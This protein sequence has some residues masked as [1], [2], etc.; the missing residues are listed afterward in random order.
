M[1]GYHRWAGGQSVTAS[2][3]SCGKPL[4][5]FILSSLVG[6]NNQISWF[7]HRGKRQKHSHAGEFQDFP[8]LHGNKTL[9]RQKIQR[10]VVHEDPVQG[11]Q[12]ISPL[13]TFPL[14]KASSRSFVIFPIP[15]QMPRTPGSQGAE[16]PA[17][18][19]SQHSPGQP[20]LCWIPSSLGSKASSSPALALPSW[21]AGRGMFFPAGA[22][23]N[24][25][26]LGS[27]RW[28]GHWAVR[29]PWSSFQYSSPAAQELQ[30]PV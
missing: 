15:M 2:L 4:T 8:T 21:D 9:P 11:E 1:S 14:P 18:S 25:H 19:F 20:G 30:A 28:S 16:L 27:P 29:R 22:L 24:S 17:L 10:A 26:G 13:Q 6:R 7:S 12:T 5:F 23:G 3:T